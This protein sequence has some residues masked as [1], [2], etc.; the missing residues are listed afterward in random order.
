MASLRP[1]GPLPTPGHMPAGSTMAAIYK[2]GYLIVGVD[3]SIP[4]LSFRDPATGEIDGFDVAIA[5][6]AAK[7][8]FGNEHAVKLVAITSAQQAGRDTLVSE[9]PEYTLLIGQARADNRDGLPLGASY[10]QE[11]SYLMRTRLLPAAA[12]LYRQENARLARSQAKAT[13]IPLIAMIV[14]VICGIVLFLAQR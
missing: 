1:S 9:I 10:L 7:A 14:A 8:I 5:R 11:A 12:E 4:L 13:S 2:R 6:Q 3:Q